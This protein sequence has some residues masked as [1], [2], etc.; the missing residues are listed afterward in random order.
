MNLIAVDIGNTNIT[1]ALYLKGEEQFIKSIPGQDRAK[2]TSLFKS[3]WQKIPI[4]K[5]SKEKKRNSVIVVSSVKADWTKQIAQIADQKLGEKILLIGKDIPF[6]MDLA[7]VV[8]AHI[9]P[10]CD[11][12]GYC[13]FGSG[14][15]HI[16]E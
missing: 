3:T 9:C 15:L 10:V 11:D 2:L 13:S 16:H 8:F 7:L 1:I 4:L 14:G 6:P 12:L 5:S